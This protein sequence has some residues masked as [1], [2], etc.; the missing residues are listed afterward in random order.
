MTSWEVLLVYNLCSMTE[1]IPKKFG[2]FSIEVL[3][4]LG[5]APCGLLFVY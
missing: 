3:R 2:L 5:G 4:S 1:G